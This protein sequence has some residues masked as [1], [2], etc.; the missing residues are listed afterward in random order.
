MHEA[1][2]KIKKPGVYRGQCTELCG[3]NHG[4][5]PIVV[6]AVS[7]ADFKQW[8][9][10]QPVVDGAAT[11]GEWVRS[12][13]SELPSVAPNMTH[14]ELMRRGKDRYLEVCAVCHR[15]D[16]LGLPPMF[17]ALKGSSLSVGR[18]VSRHI[19]IILKGV[20][21]TA[22]QAFSDQLS[23]ED[24]AAIVTYERNAWG[25]DTGDTVQ[26]A[27]VDAIRQDDMHPPIMVQKAQSGGLR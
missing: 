17:P 18:P 9:A 16:G 2:A 4:F 7:Q 19:D 26:P 24:I 6:K 15:A 3:I 23:D 25:N 27:D 12:L 1:W 8:V 10:A 20:P 11:A 14:V 5:M 21:G 13:K 22:M